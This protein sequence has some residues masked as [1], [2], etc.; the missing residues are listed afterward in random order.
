MI[1]WTE[2]KS[3]ANGDYPEKV[4]FNSIGDAIAGVI[5]DAGKADFADG[6]R[7][8][9]FH[10]RTGD[11]TV[12]SVLAG[13]MQLQDLIAQQNP[14]IGDRIAIVM[15]G[16]REV[17]KGTAKLFELQVKRGDE[18]GTPAVA[19]APAPAAPA[20]VAVSAADLI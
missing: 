7:A 3:S 14:Q 6:G 19:P 16:F 17:G 9:F 15:T 18:T 5:V 1:D 2:F 11:G 4:K 13:Q 8:P 12:W 10:I 20:P